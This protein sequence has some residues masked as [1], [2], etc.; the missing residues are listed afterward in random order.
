MRP[1]ELEILRRSVAM[2]PAGYSAGA[3]SKP[4]TTDLVW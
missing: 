4:E 2:L 3:V 1:Y